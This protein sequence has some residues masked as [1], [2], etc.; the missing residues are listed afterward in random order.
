MRIKMCQVI[1]RHINNASL[2]EKFYNIPMIKNQITFWQLTY[3]RKIFHREASQIPT[4][5]LTAWCDH[6]R[7]VG[8]PLLTNKKSIVRNIQVVLPEV[9]RTGLISKWGFHTLDAQ[10]WNDLLNSLKH[11]SHEAPQDSPNDQEPPLPTSSRSFP[12]LTP[13]PNA[14]LRKAHTDTHLPP[15]LLHLQNLLQGPRRRGAH[16]NTISL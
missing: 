5:L 6:P 13:P 10:H 15:L 9:D 8:R 7:K 12:S 1:D 4:R 2:R 14:T 3:L 11:S 16:P